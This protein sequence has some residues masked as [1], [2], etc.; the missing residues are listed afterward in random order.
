[1]D[2]EFDEKFIEF[3]REKYDFLLLGAAL[4]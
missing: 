4:D 3:P 2:L 1:M